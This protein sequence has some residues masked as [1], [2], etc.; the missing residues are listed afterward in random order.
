MTNLTEKLDELAERMEAKFDEVIA[1]ITALRG[2]GPENTIKSVNESIWNVAG[3]A[4]GRNLAEI[5]AALVGDDSDP[6]DIRTTIWGL[7][8]AAPGKTLADIHAALV[9]G[10]G[11]PYL[12]N[13]GLVLGYNPSYPYH[14]SGQLADIVDNLKPTSGYYLWEIL[15]NLNNAVGGVP[16]ESLQLGTVRGLL[17]AVRICCE[18]SAGGTSCSIHFAGEASATAGEGQYSIT[19]WEGDLVD[20]DTYDYFEVTV[21][22][23]ENLDDCHIVVEGPDSFYESWGSRA[24]DWENGY[25]VTH[26]NSFSWPDG[27][28]KISVGSNYQPPEGALI[29]EHT[30]AALVTI[31]HCTEPYSGG[32]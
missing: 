1:A 9:T 21:N 6:I 12:Q 8:G 14:I 16:N 26:W 7:A 19:L 13:I 27:F 15:T 29:W 22:S 24:Q 2:D 18:E 25:T 23:S 4:P 28:W 30:Y 5:Y 20:V 17:D 11:D 3:P 10:G 31:K 32:S